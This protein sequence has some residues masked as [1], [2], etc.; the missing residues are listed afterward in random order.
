MVERRRAVLIAAG[1][2]ANL[3]CALDY[4]GLSFAEVRGRGTG[5]VDCP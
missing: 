2:C 1:P 4:C 3:Q 5:Q